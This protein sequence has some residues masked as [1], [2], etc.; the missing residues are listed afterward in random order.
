M[1]LLEGV[2]KPTLLL[3]IDTGVCGDRLREKADLPGVTASRENTLASGFLK[4]KN[5]EAT[6]AIVEV[7]DCGEGERRGEISSGFRLALVVQN[8]GGGDGG[9]VRRDR[10]RSRGASDMMESMVRL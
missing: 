9:E 8:P 3:E 4:G 2:A 10:E 1:A 5:D 7:G 6:E